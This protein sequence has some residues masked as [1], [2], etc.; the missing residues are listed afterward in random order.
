M[1]VRAIRNNNPGNIRIG[2]HWQGLMEPSAMTPEQHA[3]NA[4]CVFS[5]PRWGF[6]AM[7]VIFH[8]YHD[9]DGVKTLRQAISRWAPPNEN[10]TE[11]YVQA[12]CASCET[13]PDVPFVFSDVSIMRL[14][15]LTTRP[16]ISDGSTVVESATSLPPATPMSAA[17]SAADCVSESGSAEATS[18]VT[19]P[20]WA[21]T[22][23]R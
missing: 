11:A 12:V 4:F 21:A 3:E 2:A 17:L 19:S 7:A 8:T 1:S 6:R 13:H 16:P 23:A 22:S 9:H 20:R 5:A 18:A 14:P 15:T 10:N